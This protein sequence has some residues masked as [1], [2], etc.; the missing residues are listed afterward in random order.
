MCNDSLT[1]N[2]PSNATTAEAIITRVN[3][4]YSAR[5]WVSFG[6]AGAVLNIFE[7]FFIYF[8][9]KHRTVFGLTLASLCVADLLGG[10]SF[11][12]AGALRLYEYDGSLTVR[13]IADTSFSVTWKAGHGVLFFSVGTSFIHIMIIAVQRLFAV[14]SPIAFKTWFTRRRC[15]ILLI[16]TWALLLITGVIGYFFIKGIWT[17]SYY[18]MLIVGSV[19]VLCYTA[20]CCKAYAHSKKRRL[21]TI[22]VESKSGMEKTVS[23]SV[24]ITIAFLVCTLPQAIFYLYILDSDDLTFY[25]SVNCLISMNPFLDSV[26]YFCFYHDFSRNKSSRRRNQT[27]TTPIMQHKSAASQKK[28]NVPLTSKG[29]K[30]LL[31]DSVASVTV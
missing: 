8:K 7:G 5:F 30:Q 6:V 29:S 23:L 15:A 24:A 17:V 11:T 4:Y 20:I 22:S 13:I 3:W 28:D 19:L 9:S 1:T 27:H 12:I 14:F 31:Q 21:M 10:I 2:G 18:L 26:I 25:H 16:V